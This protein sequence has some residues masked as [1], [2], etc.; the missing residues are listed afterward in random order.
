MN[1]VLRG[2]FNERE[3]TPGAVPCL[4]DLNI[5]NNKDIYDAWMM[6][7]SKEYDFVDL[8]IYSRNNLEVIIRVRVTDYCLEPDRFMIRLCNKTFRSLMKLVDEPEVERVEIVRWR[9][10]ECIILYSTAN[11]PLRGIRLLAKLDISGQFRILGY[12]PVGDDSIE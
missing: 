9:D 8:L 7:N 6:L 1:E 11:P 4:E 5:I 2:E 10:K 3:P 12:R